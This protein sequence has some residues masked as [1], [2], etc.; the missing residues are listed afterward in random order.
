MATVGISARFDTH[1]LEDT[2]CAATHPPSRVALFGI[3]FIIIAACSD[4]PTSAA[5]RP[6]TVSLTTQVQGSVASRSLSDITIAVGAATLVLTKA[7]L[8]ARRIELAPASATGCGGVEENG[9]DDAGISDGCA[10]VEAG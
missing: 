9:D 6:L 2:M 4:A 7:Q 8:V 5:R 3:A 1:A 10:E